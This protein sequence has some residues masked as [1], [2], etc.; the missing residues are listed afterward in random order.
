MFF[1]T[2]LWFIRFVVNIYR[3]GSTKI[4]FS[5]YIEHIKKGRLLI[6]LKK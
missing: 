6:K 5:E 1:E 2:F 4:I 3:L